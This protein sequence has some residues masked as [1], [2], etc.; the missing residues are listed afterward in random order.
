MIYVASVYSL[1]AKGNSGHDIALR[2]KRYDY[3]VERVGKWME[4]GTI[5]LFSPI[6]HCH[7][8]ANRGHL[9]KDYTFWQ[10]NDRHMIERCDEIWVLM[11]PGWER[12]VGVKDEI[13]YGSAINKK[14][15]YFECNDYKGV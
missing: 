11:M 13:A 5:G 1:D 9:P 14:V 3:V 10:E 7:V 6:A 4:S 2:E 15:V 8:P 12:S